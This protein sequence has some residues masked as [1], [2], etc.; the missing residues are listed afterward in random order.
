[1]K[2]RESEM[3]KIL[4]EKLKEAKE[5][6]VASIARA[7]HLRLL[8]TDIGR[9]AQNELDRLEQER[10]VREELKRMGGEQKEPYILTSYYQSMIAHN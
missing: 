4:G 1:M 2:E 7:E 6:P 8:I 3:L 10:K 5:S 9:I